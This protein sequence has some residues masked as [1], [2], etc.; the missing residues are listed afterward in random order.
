MKEADL[1]NSDSRGIDVNMVVFFQQK[2]VAFQSEIGKSVN[3]QMGFWRELEQ[4]NPNVQKLLAL[5]SKITIQ[6]ETVTTTYSKLIEINPNHVGILRVYG[7]FLKDIMNDIIESQ[8]V[9]EK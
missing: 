1:R 9:L 2:F 6:A 3:M 7:N 4:S 5:G 8:R